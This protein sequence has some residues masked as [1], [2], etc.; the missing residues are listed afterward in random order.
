MQDYVM[1]CAGEFEELI[2]VIDYLTEDTVSNDH[3]AVQIDYMKQ[4]ME[5]VLYL[6]KTNALY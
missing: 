2:G 1:Q 3:K 5:E 4:K 6:L